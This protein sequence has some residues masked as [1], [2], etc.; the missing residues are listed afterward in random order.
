MTRPPTFTGIRGNIQM[1]KKTVLS[2][3]GW[4]D[5]PS[6]LL[7]LLPPVNFKTI[8]VAQTMKQAQINATTRSKPLTGGAIGQERSGIATPLTQHCGASG[9]GKI[10]V[11]EKQNQTAVATMMQTKY[12]LSVH[13]ATTCG[14]IIIILMTATT[15]TTTVTEQATAITTMA[16]MT[17]PG[18]HPATSRPR[19]LRPGADGASRRL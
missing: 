18:D 10:G 15:M 19:D 9:A 12:L 5:A 2:Q 14:A 17:M 8:L 6:H 1:K 4:K 11:K 16:G 13:G 3:R 7:A